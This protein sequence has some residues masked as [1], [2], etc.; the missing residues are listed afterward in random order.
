M[1]TILLIDD[2]PL[3]VETYSAALRKSGYHVIEADSGNTGLT[4]ARK[5]LPDL[6]ISDID[7]PGGDGATLLRDIRSDP[8]LRSKQV[9]IITGRPD[10]VAPRKGMEEGADDFLVKPVNLEAL[11]SCVE[12]RFRRAAISWR[13]EDQLLAQLRS[14]VPSQLSHEFFTP[15]AGIIGLL[16]ILRSGCPSFSSEEVQDIHND[17]YQSAFRLNRTLRNYL[18]I[19]D[20]Q[21]AA[22]TAATKSLSSN[23]VETNILAGVEEV[24]RLNNRRQ[25]VTV[26]VKA[27]SLLVNPDY[28]CHIIEELVDNACKFSRHGTPVIVELGDDGRLT[29]TD[30]GRGLTAEQISRIGA[31]HQFDR[32]TH[33]QQ[34]L[35]LGLVLVQKLTAQS[36]A[37]FSIKSNPGEW[38]QAQ[39][40]FSLASPA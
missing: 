30:R 32:K 25:D 38:T 27:C 17:L 10:L 16:Q 21:N 6:I 37:E 35:G 36:T 18:L 14:A 39:I 7:M 40:A 19:L 31:F 1:K 3:L 20:L 13:V 34:G 15:M 28:L 11:L 2:S 29:I 9:V 4:L 23:E 8:E 22:A 5:H 24:L 33:A 26:R 12:A